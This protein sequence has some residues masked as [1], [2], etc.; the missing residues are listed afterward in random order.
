VSELQVHELQ[1]I[2]R[3]AINDILED[4]EEEFEERYSDVTLFNLPCKHCSQ[5][6]KP[7]QSFVLFHGDC[8]D[9]ENAL[10]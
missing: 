6:I 8:V 10:R 2:I 9:K 1:D 5:P 4:R 3:G 7:N